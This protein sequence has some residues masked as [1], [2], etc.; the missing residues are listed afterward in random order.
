MLEKRQNWVKIDQKEKKNATMVINCKVY[1]KK[2]KTIPFK[3]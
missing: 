1:Y 3:R 2:V